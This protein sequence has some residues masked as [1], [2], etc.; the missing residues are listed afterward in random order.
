MD[1]ADKLLLKVGVPPHLSGYRYIKAALE[2]K[3]TQRMMTLYQR[4]A[5]R[6]GSKAI[7]VERCMRHA[8]EA[9]FDRMEPAVQE[10]IFGSTVSG[11]KGKATNSAFLMTLRLYLEGEA[12]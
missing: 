12:E 6:Y 3:D 8:V 4:V 2:E 11:W 9:A 1:K 10:E 5:D 7:L